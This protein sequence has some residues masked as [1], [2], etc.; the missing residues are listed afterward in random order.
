MEEKSLILF[1]EKEI[2][3]VWHNEEWYFS[4]VDIVGILSD[5]SD[6]SNYWTT[7]KLRDT[8]LPTICRRLKLL[9]VDGKKRL[10]DCANNS[11]GQTSR[12]KYQQYPRLKNTILHCTILF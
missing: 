8:Q 4:V 11:M 2:R 1:G 9:A 6:P 7:V 10:T 3:K 12:I 5:S